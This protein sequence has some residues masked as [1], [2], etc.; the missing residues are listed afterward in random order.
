MFE[1]NCIQFCDTSFSPELL[2]T[3]NHG[4][5][6]S[7]GGLETENWNAMRRGGE[8]GSPV[9]PPSAEIGGVS[10][11]D[12]G[13]RWWQYVY[14][15]PQDDNPQLDH[16]G[17]FAGVNQRADSPVFFLMGSSGTSETREIVVPSGKYL[18]FPIF[19]MEVEN[20]STPTLPWGPL[21]LQQI[22]DAMAPYVDEFGKSGTLSASI[23]GKEVPNVL[24]YRQQSS[25]P[26]SYVLP[27]NNIYYA[28][29]TAD[30]GSTINNPAELGGVVDI[31]HLP[32]TITP[33]L[34]DGYWMMVKPLSVGE[35]T[36]HF[37]A[38]VEAWNFK[39]DITYHITVA[40]F[41][42]I[43]G[44]EGNNTLQG[45]CGNDEID[46]LGGNDVVYGG[47]GNDIIDGGAGN[48]K[49][50]GGTGNDILYGGAGNDKLYGGTG[51]DILAGGAGNDRLYGGAGND[52]LYGGSGNDIL[53][54]GAG[55]DTFVYRSGDGRDLILD[56][57]QGQDVID[58]SSF[59]YANK[60][61]AIADGVSF[62]GNTITF[63]SGDS[64][65]LKNVD[66]SALAESSFIFQVT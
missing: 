33:V 59:G 28:G 20:I 8:S 46:A 7:S 24:G 48:D 27:E 9:L 37:S 17:D 42:P 65:T 61:A 13:D 16:T 60:A 26:F 44:T 2:T 34:A 53:S 22:K 54:G 47:A 23:D 10:Q 56:F 25:Q 6:R 11:A 41:T 36:I 50:Y 38:S 19:N 40:P 21:D 39:L 55:R 3:R 14:S 31:N 45:T 12:Y 66:V 64:L 35:H 18:F 58:L 4:F 1:R 51:N 63:K 62:T 57:T 5:A 43:M 49:L 29:V 15:V 30:N 52:R 32:I